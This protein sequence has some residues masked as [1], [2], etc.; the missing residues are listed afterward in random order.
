VDVMNYLQN[1][2]DYHEQSFREAFQI[3]CLVNP[4]TGELR[5]FTR[6]HSLEMNNSTIETEEYALTS[7]LSR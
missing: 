6:K 3:S 7:L 2:I 1:A 5:I 4:S